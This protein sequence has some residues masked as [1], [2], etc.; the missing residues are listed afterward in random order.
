M[1]FK[2][3]SKYLIL[4]MTIVNMSCKNNEANTS[5]K[6][7]T[8][9]PQKKSDD[10]INITT[11]FVPNQTNFG[12]AVAGQKYNPF[13]MRGPNSFYR[14]AMD[15]QMLGFK[16][17]KIWLNVELLGFDSVIPTSERS[18]ISSAIDIL[19]RPEYQKI[20]NLDFDTFDFLVDSFSDTANIW[21]AAAQGYS[22]AD[23][24]EIYN[25]MYQTAT[26]LLNR[27]NGTGKTIILQ[28]HEGDWHMFDIN[29][30]KPP[31]DQ[32][33]QNMTAYL[34]IRQTA[35]ND[36]RKNSNAQNV[37][38]YHMCEVVNVVK[39]MQTG[40]P[41][42]VNKILPNV[43]CD[44]VGYSAYDSSLNSATLFSQ[45]YNYIRSNARP[46]PFFGNNQVAVSEL[47]YT[48]RQ[49]GAA[50]LKL[51]Q[52]SLKYAVEQSAPYILLW[53]SYDNECGTGTALPMGASLKTSDCNGFWVRRPD[54]TLSEMYKSTLKYLSLSGTSYLQN[55]YRF[56]LDRDAS[57]DEI[58]NLQNTF[59]TGSVPE[60][61]AMIQN[62]DEAKSS[63]VKRLYQEV[64]NR[65][66]DHEGYANWM[67]RIKQP[68]QLLVD[69]SNEFLRTAYKELS[70]SNPQSP[71]AC[72]NALLASKQTLLANQSLTSCNRQYTL[73][74]QNDGN[75]LLNRSDNKA[76]WATNTGNSNGSSFVMQ[77]DG[78]VVLYAGGTGKSL[79]SSN[80]GGHPGAYLVVQ[81][82]GNLAIYAANTSEKP[83]WS[84]PQ[85]VCSSTLQDGQELAAD[86]SIT[87]CNGQ[88][89]LVVQSDGNLVVYDSGG[90]ALWSTNTGGKGG[91][92]AVMQNDGN[93][94][95]YQSQ[96]GK[97]LWTS[98]TGGNPG[99]SATIQD[100]GNFVIYSSQSPGK[101]LWSWKTSR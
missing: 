8:M 34:A 84:V 39:P 62:S 37:K 101:A 12:V 67:T 53:T 25:S 46:S 1:T 29:S 74:L 82:D 31:T 50:R 88:F 52:D 42:I 57:S 47:G 64:L 72:N 71:Y 60:I 22:E 44:L 100:D 69:A 26:W 15:M 98:N 95:L 51:Y 61:D 59:N 54:G 79:W 49:D 77:E 56:F 43:T 89:S 33:L 16:T 48:E 86:Q 14:T 83:I 75:V 32:Q 70:Q 40:F 41:G 30:D 92:S 73:S 5:P 96:T 65:E 19:N 21:A 2:E 9:S 4:A 97:V 18:K 27:F 7:V 11:T 13:G 35:V 28:N 45:A 90:K 3:L 63:Y 23:K 68:G 85:K 94:V 93:L 81:D 78:N 55:A 80:T 58:N 24:Q 20:L 38:I 36:A 76:V 17:L 91:K 87:S 66:P 6:S 10:A 99:A